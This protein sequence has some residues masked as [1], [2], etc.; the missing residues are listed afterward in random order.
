MRERR[1]HFPRWA[2][3]KIILWVLSLVI[4]TQLILFVIY[5]QKNTS[6]QFKINRDVI[7][8]QVINLIQTVENTPEDQQADL[9]SALSIP[10]FSVSISSKPKWNP[11]F[12]T[13]S[14]WHIL[15]KISEQAPDIQL[16]FYLSNSKWLNILA[17]IEP[18]SSL[19]ALLLLG[20]EV[21]LT[22]TILVSL[23]SINRYTKPLKNFIE[24]ADKL[25][26]DVRTK[27]LPIDGP[28]AIRA[29]ADAMNRMQQRITDLLTARTQMLAAIS[30]DLRTPITRLKLRAQYVDEPK[31]QEKIIGDLD[32][33]EAMLAETLAF[34]REEGRKEERVLLD[35]A[36]LVDSVCEDFASVGHTIEYLGVFE[37]CTYYGGPV[38]L[39]RVLNN[40]LENAIKYAGN[41]RVKLEIVKDEYLISV[42]DD[43]PGIPKSQLTQVFL[44]FY[45]GEHSR[46]RQTGGM[47]LGLAVAKDIIRAHGGNIELTSRETGG[48]MVLIRLPVQL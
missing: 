47:G 4:I 29:M 30:H 3:G 8:R 25:G 20:M 15:W 40:I 31:L 13:S 14:L 27:P 11:Q 41:A 45:R 1:F 10:N 42:E 7:A 44:P 12:Q 34:A 5:S 19:L 9:V 24:A 17:K 26:V 18:Q 35:L 46:S 32:Q 28:A 43:G 38:G 36:S 39:K 37:R 21:A 23:L 48:L 22:L 16:S 6:A 33:M 2:F